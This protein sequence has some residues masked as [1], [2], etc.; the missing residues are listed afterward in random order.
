[1][2]KANCGR[3][4]EWKQCGSTWI[5]RRCIQNYAVW[6]DRSRFDYFYTM[7]IVYFNEICNLEMII[8]LQLFLFI[9]KAKIELCRLSEYNHLSKTSIREN[10]LLRTKWIYYKIAFCIIQ[11]APP[12]TFFERRHNQPITKSQ[13]ELEYCKRSDWSIPVHAP[14]VL[15]QHQLGGNLWE[16]CLPRIGYLWPCF[17]HKK[18]FV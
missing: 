13:P 17:W 9:S 7:F 3:D 8:L 6:P 18:P 5:W 15:Q 16:P 11:R 14:G 4:K 10:T 12:F 1:M 2:F